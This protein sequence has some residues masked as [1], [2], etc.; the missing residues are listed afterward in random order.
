MDSRRFY[1]PSGGAILARL[2]TSPVIRSE[3]ERLLSWEERH[4]RLLARIA[5][6]LLLT[7][8]VDVVGAVLTWK[9]E[10]GVENGDI[11]SFSDA[12]FFSTTQLLT[13][14]SQIQNPFTTGGRIVDVVLE[15]WAVVVVAGVAGSFA[16]FFSATDRA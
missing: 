14:S 10:H 3:L 13:V 9:F 11:H 2:Q 12:L 1:S 7:L 16:A 4:R 6:A 5:L 15:L 8:A